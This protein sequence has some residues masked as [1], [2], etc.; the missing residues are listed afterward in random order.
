MYYSLS[1]QQKY[2]G[3][4][5][6]LS[7]TG[8]YENFAEGVNDA[9][10][11]LLVVPSTNEIRWIESLQELLLGTG[12]DEWRIGTNELQTPLTPTNFS[13]KQQSTRGSRDMQ[14]KKVADTLLFVDFVGRKIRELAYDDRIGKYLTPDM[15]VLAEDITL[16]GIVCIAHQKNPDSILWCVL[17]DGSLLSMT[18]DRE[19]NVV[20]WANHPIGGTD[21][22]VQSVAVIPGVAEDEIW[23]S[24]SRTVNSSTVIYI[25]QMQ[26]RT[27]G[28]DLDDAF[29]VDSGLTF[30][31]QLLTVDTT[32]APAA[33]SVG[34]TI[35]GATSGTTAQII[36]VLTATTYEIAYLT[37]DFTLSEVLSDGTNS[38]DTA[39]AYPTVADTSSTAIGGLLHLVGETVIV[40]GDG[41]E[42][43]P[44]AVVDAN[45]AVVIGTAVEKAQV[46]LSN[47][48]K[49]QP[50][51]PDVMTAGGSSHGSKVKVAE[52]VIS[53]LNTA[54]AKYGVSDSTLKE[55]DFE[56]PDWVNESSITGLFTGDIPVVVDGGFSINNP[57][58]ISDNGAMPCTIRALVPRMDITGR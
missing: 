41:T 26:P 6:W 57:L 12:A 48:Y 58:I 14:P 53:F 7:S 3:Q 5:V 20:A 34:A 16:S 1:S 51:R 49:L 2:V 15:T 9:D 50:T 24:V 13:V 46:G 39:A 44:T 18:Y 31:P 45:G 40:L 17:T 38:I 22:S 42:Y 47:T 11:F 37:G 29:F 30:T 56:Y 10:S 19:Q 43:T 27:F 32:P 23:I 21:V 28:T 54:A 55:I 36:K 52:M 33:W 25:E 4:T 8:D 35:T